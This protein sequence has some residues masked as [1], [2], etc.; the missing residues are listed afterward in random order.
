[1]YN[2]M[3][4]IKLL[5]SMGCM[6]GV[7]ESVDQSELKHKDQLLLLDSLSLDRDIKQLALRKKRKMVKEKLWQL[8]K[9][10]MTFLQL[11]F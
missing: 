4:K 10:M 5:S 7:F 6:G 11:Q 1:M 8:C 3:N 9:Q 2:T